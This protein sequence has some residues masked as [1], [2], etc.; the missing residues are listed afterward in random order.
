[1]TAGA[2]EPDHEDGRTI[3]RRTTPLDLAA[4]LRSID[5]QWPGWE[6]RDGQEVPAPWGFL[7]GVESPGGRLLHRPL[8]AHPAQALA[9]W[10]AP[11][12]WCAVGV[13]VR[14][15]AHRPRDGHRT[16]EDARVIW[17]CHRDGRSASLLGLAGEPVAVVVTDP[18]ARGD[19]G[20]AK[21]SGGAA[22]PGAG[23]GHGSEA[24]G[25]PD[26]DGRVPRLLREALT[27]LPSGMARRRGTTP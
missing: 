11:G 23:R 14:G 3:P 24:G 22:T 20:A 6:R 2:P 12:R 15:T 21:G 1:M 13:A 7:V 4:L 9:G 5:G 19:G 27:P 18:V 17:V 26:E 8:P 10:V 25:D 16:A